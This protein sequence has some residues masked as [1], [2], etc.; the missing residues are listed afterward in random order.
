[1]ID[2]AIVGGGPA[3]Y[4]AAIFAGRAGLNAVVYESELMAGKIVSISQIEN[5]PGFPNGISG[6]KLSDNLHKQA[7]KLGVDTVYN[8]VKK[9]GLDGKYKEIL[10]DSGETIKAKAVILAIGEMAQKLNCAGEKKFL[11]K[12]VSY[13][14]ICDGA[15]FKGRDVAVIGG[16][17]AALASA[18]YLCHLVKK[19][20]LVHRRND[21][22]A[23]KILQ[24]KLKQCEMA[25]LVLNHEVKEIQGKKFVNGML[26]QNKETKTVKRIDVDGVFVYVGSKPN[27][28]IVHEIVKV[29]EQGY[30]ITNEKMETSC[31]GIYAAGD[32]RKKDLRQLVTAAAD[33]AIASFQARQYIEMYY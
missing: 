15:F 31:P 25:E 2:I 17:D 5:Y 30:I 24:D 10:I 1:M 8:E 12:G 13:C 6:E 26:L 21:L 4:T 3:A 20:Y 11:G 18:L 22:R 23:T 33:G 7:E 14:A 32:V 9:V 19:L 28:E 29:D 27:T 16:G